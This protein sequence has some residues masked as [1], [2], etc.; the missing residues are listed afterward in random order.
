MTESVYS[1]YP[2]ALDSAQKEFLVKTIKD[3]ATQNGLVVRPS[4]TFVAKENDPQGV[5]A[6]NAPVTLFP[7]L[8]PKACFE[9]A[10][11]LQ[12]VYN[13]L[14]AAITCDEDWIGKI[15]EE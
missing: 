9:E 1:S 10:R 15:M 12:T 11:A 4:P 7:S 6:T 3:W 5:L 14:Y 13:Q 2:P 8:F